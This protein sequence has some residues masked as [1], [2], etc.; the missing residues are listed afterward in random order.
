MF[1]ED[2]SRVDDLLDKSL[3]DLGPVNR[4]VQLTRAWTAERIAPEVLP[5]PK[6]LV[7]DLTA[8][9]RSQIEFVEQTELT[10]LKVNFQLVVIQTEL[11]RIKYLLRS[12]LRTRLCKLDK[13][14]YYYLNDSLVKSRLS[15]LE[16]QYLQKHQAIVERHL[17][18]TFIKDLPESGGLHKLDDKAAAGVS[19]VDAPD[20]KRPVF[21]KVAQALT[22]RLVIGDEAL[23]VDIG[24]VILINYDAVRRHVYKVRQLQFIICEANIYRKLSSSYKS[25]TSPL[26]PVSGTMS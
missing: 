13:C 20:L 10:D 7:D 6:L 9:L 24:S 16:I 2:S 17:F 18:A 5:F 8:A 26:L 19:M 22:Q 25:S 3:S 11:E 15:S 14:P 4:I 23:E 21:C 12:Y 1:E